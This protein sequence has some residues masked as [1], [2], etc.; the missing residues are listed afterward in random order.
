MAHI[1]NGLKDK[2]PVNTGLLK[3]W[4]S[5]RDYR[6]EPRKAFQINYLGS[7][8]WKILAT[9]IATRSEVVIL[10]RGQDD[11]LALALPAGEPQD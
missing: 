6:A 2:R 7:S 11:A 1:G 3:D 9:S 4:R 10:L 8:G 5:G